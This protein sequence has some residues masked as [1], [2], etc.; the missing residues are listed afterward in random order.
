MQNRD[1]GWRGQY[2][3][4]ICT[5]ERECYC[6]EKTDGQVVETPCMATLHQTQTE[7][8]YKKG[9][10]NQGHRKNLSSIIRG[11]KSAVTKDAIPQGFSS[12]PAQ[13]MIPK[14]CQQD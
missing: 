14:R 7:D 2:Y 4:T 1:Y 11:F 12:I 6:G 9:T 10:T 5:R 13:A 8:Y 3:I